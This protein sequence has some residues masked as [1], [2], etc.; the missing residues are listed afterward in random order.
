MQLIHCRRIEFIGRQVVGEQVHQAI[1]AHRH[2]GHKVCMDVV[3]Q[4]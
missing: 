3:L 2:S 1:L 4:A